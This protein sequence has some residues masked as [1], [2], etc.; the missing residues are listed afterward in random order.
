MLKGFKEFILRGNSIDL[1][2][3][4]VM[5]AAFGSVV[6]ALVKDL[7]TPFVGAVVKTSDFAGLAF[8]LNGSKFMYGDFI[9]ALI[10]FVLIAAAVYFFVITP[11]NIFMARVR[12]NPPAVSN[13]KKCP[14][15]LSEIPKEAKR[16]A[17]C[18]QTV[19]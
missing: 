17:F 13:T 16:C 4:V 11:M 10:S 6:T 15:C 5:G 8:S 9:N 19:V 18:G 2:V 3:G 1:A 14:E 12:K 7:L